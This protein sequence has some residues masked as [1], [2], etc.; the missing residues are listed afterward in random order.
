MFIP[1]LEYR[2]YIQRPRSAEEKNKKLINL[3]L[4][5][6]KV[7]R[8]NLPYQDIVREIARAFNAGEDI[9]NPEIFPKEA[10]AQFAKENKIENDPMVEKFIEKAM[11]ESWWA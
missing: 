8:S 4:K 5:T 7:T 11:P 1:A 3:A 10:I 6:K 2:K 9:L